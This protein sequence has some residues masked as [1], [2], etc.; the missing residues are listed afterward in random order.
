MQSINLLYYVIAICNSNRGS[1]VYSW[2]A[3]ASNIHR[4][5]LHHSFFSETLLKCN[6]STD[7]QES[8]FVCP[9]FGTC[10]G[11]N[12]HLLMWA[13]NFLVG[14]T[15]GCG[16]SP[17]LGDPLRDEGTGEPQ[18]SLELLR[19]TFGLCGALQEETLSCSASGFL[20]QTQCVLSRH[21]WWSFTN[22]QWCVSRKSHILS[23][24]ML[25]R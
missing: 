4:Y 1:A 3:L 22:Y 24:T 7:S 15:W 12:L 8:C 23:S 19:V 2:G 11:P 5:I 25:G 10:W 9:H 16:G 18:Q 6:R 21:K 17:A 13:P 20:M 14:S